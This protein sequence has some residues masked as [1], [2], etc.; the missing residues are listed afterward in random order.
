MN[1][2]AP[3][4]ESVLEKPVYFAHPMSDYGSLLE[5]R[6]LIHLDKWTR[7]MGGVENPNKVKHAL[8]FR[9]QGMTYFDKVILPHIWG[10]VYM[11]FP[12]GWIGAGVG[13]EIRRCFDKGLPV[14][15]VHRK[16]LMVEPKK[17]MPRNVCTVEKTRELLKVY[18]L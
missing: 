12:C 5:A 4:S 17:R 6:I 14:F 18:G 1:F 16:T 11:A 9:E 13:Y 10:T 15:Q 3:Y 8:G 2:V 7:G